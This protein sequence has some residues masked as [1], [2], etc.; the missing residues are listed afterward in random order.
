MSQE[1]RLFIEQVVQRELEEQAV[2]TYQASARGLAIF[3]AKPT[4]ARDIILYN[5]GRYP[6]EG[7]IMGIINTEYNGDCGAWEVLTVAAI[8]GYGPLLY[9][10]AF[11]MSGRR[12]LM[13]DRNTVSPSAL[14][15]WEYYF[16]RRK[17][18][19]DIIPL[20]PDCESDNKL[21]KLTHPEGPL[22]FRYVPKAPMDISGLEL[23]HKRFLEDLEPNERGRAITAIENGGYDFFRTKYNQ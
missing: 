22:N 4:N 23:N 13:A 15:V 5:P 12:G 14:R 9:D 17:E 21:H 2:S 1:I 11:S 18:E 19:F 16:S 7:F 3:I 8:K 10:I 20:E 6:D